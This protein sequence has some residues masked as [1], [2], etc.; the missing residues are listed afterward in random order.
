MTEE[1]KIKLSALDAKCFVCDCDMSAQKYVNAD[2]MPNY[3]FLSNKICCDKCDIGMMK[4]ARL[5]VIPLPDG[6]KVLATSLKGACLVEYNARVFW[7]PPKVVAQIK[8]GKISP[9]IKYGGENSPTTAEEYKKTGVV[10]RF[11]VLPPK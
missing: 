2:Y 7:V 11:S 4:P 1:I 5:L 6:V 8:K 10:H 3:G 9:A